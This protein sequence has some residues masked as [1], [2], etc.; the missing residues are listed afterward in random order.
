MVNVFILVLLG[1]IPPSRREKE[2][3]YITCPVRFSCY[4]YAFE[5]DKYILFNYV[6]LHPHPSSEEEGCCCNK[7]KDDGVYIDY[8]WPCNTP[9]FCIANP[10]LTKIPYLISVEAWNHTVHASNLRY[11]DVFCIISTLAQRASLERA[12]TFREYIRKRAL[13]YFV[14]ERRELITPIQALIDGK[15]QINPCGVIL[16]NTAA[17]LACELFRRIVAYL[18]F[19]HANTW[20]L[21]SL[22]AE[23]TK[24]L[25]GCTDKSRLS[26]GAEEIVKRERTLWILSHSRLTNLGGCGTGDHD[27]YGCF[28]KDVHVLENDAAVPLVY[29]LPHTMLTVEPTKSYIILLEVYQ[30]LQL[31]SE[32]LCKRLTAEQLC[33]AEKTVHLETVEPKYIVG[34]RLFFDKPFIDLEL[35]EGVE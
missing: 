5:E 14:E 29:P 18:M 25:E 32:E 8:G 2:K 30:S 22:S 20:V 31:A 4:D 6:K 16:S 11:C 35:D 1:H 27:T 24:E 7:E 10:K 9:F 21:C 17:A 26:I 28:N 19:I 33:I 3:Y 12:G 13:E 34:D 23:E 15:G